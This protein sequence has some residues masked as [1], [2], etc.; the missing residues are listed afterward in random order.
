MIYICIHAHAYTVSCTASRCASSI[1]CPARKLTTETLALL[2]AL[3]LLSKSIVSWGW[4][5]SHAVSRYQDRSGIG[6]AV[7]VVSVLW[8]KSELVSHVRDQHQK[9]WPGRSHLVPKPSKEVSPSFFCLSA[10]G[11]VVLLTRKL[12][13]PDMTKPEGGTITVQMQYRP[14]EP[15]DMHETL[16][17]P[18][19]PEPEPEWCSLPKNRCF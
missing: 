15:S 5:I 13:S 1:L 19:W 17:E 4:D 11:E 12:L 10:A 7:L 18:E 3:H 9:L 8:C 16:K 2:H 14:V 6:S